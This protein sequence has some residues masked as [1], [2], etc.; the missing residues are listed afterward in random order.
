MSRKVA[1]LVFALGSAACLV[2]ASGWTM[3][4]P[5]E[6]VVVRRLGRL[7]EPPWGPGLHWRLPLGIDQADRVRSDAVRQLTIGLATG[8]ES[9]REPS[10]GEVMTGDLNLLRI[11][12]TV[13]YRV[14]RSAAWILRS[15]Q[16]EGLLAAAAQASVSRALAARSVDA[17][18]RSDRQALTRDVGYDLQ[19]AV[20]G[21][22]L[23]VAILGISVTDARPPVEVEAD[24]AAA[25]S[26]ESQRDRRINEARS[27]EQTTETSARSLAG[28]RLESAHTAA[29]RTVLAA[30]AESQRFLAL[31]A[32][33]D[34]ARALTMR[35]LYIESLQALLSRVKSKL[36][37]SSG[38]AIDLT[39][40][41]AQPAGAPAAAKPIGDDRPQAAAP[42]GKK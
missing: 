10:A 31:L 29:E 7:V 27:Y 13:Q 9:G 30:R 6:V 33:A 20:D 2:F 36:I 35:R 28:A 41:G 4:A 24:F 34:P 22:G 16:V 39:V 15:A 19:A 38:D 26:A 32:R 40:L 25:Q 1:T 18:L 3:V 5:G 11:Q 42:D 21:Y 12:A 8:A 14:V 17:V 23:G 37:L